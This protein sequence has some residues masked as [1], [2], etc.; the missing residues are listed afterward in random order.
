MNTHNISG[1]R[2]LLNW[3]IQHSGQYYN[4]ASH[5]TYVQC[6]HF[7]HEWWEP[8][9]PNKLL[10]I[11]VFTLTVFA[12]SFCWVKVPKVNFFHISYCSRCLRVGVRTRNWC[13]KSQYGFICNTLTALVNFGRLA[14]KR[15]FDLFPLVT[16]RELVV[17][18][19][20]RERNLRV[21]L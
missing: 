10:M 13:L 9:L 19:P 7:I 20:G 1:A 2:T 5:T 8:K 14:K 12:R 3:S 16:T 17:W 15:Q 21:I 18:H 4:L 11:I 6:V